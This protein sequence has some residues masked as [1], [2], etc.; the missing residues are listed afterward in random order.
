MVKTII[1]RAPG[2]N[3]DKETAFAFEKAGAQT[4]IIHVNE[5]IKKRDIIEKFK[6]LVIPGGFSYG[7]DIAAGRIFANELKQRLKEKLVSFI[8]SGRI[9]I[10][11][12]NGFQVLVE[13]GILPDKNLQRKVALI[14][15][16]SGKFEDRWVY[17]KVKNS[18]VFTKGIEGKILYLPVA[19]AEGKFF[20]KQNVLKKIKENKQ[21][22]FE[23]VN[24]KGNPADYPY[25]PNGALLNIAG[26]INETGNVLGMMPHPERYI[27]KYQH[28]R[29]T[30]EKLPDIGDGLIIIRNAVNFA[31]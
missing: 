5:L 24:K 9:A 23:Y 29:W 3:C 11:I 19:H 30:R 15:N 21:I 20:T 14:T 18:S 10:G 16:D 7:D 6:I 17:L 1:L 8:N 13:L 2:T 22:I 25:N 12:C 31:K 26:I 27:T 28:P 4:S